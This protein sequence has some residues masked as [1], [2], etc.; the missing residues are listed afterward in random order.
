MALDPQFVASR[1][2]RALTTL[3]DAQPLLRTPQFHTIHAGARAAEQ[4]GA[5]LAGLGH[6][7]GGD[8]VTGA[9]GLML[10]T[11]DM[12]ARTRLLGDVERGIAQLRAAL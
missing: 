8:L 9:R 1:L 11:T 4:A 2:T 5:T 3:V 6:A 12:A 10:D 7:I